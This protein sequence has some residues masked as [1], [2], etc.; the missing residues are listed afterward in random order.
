MKSLM[1]TCVYASLHVEELDIVGLVGKTKYDELKSST[2]KLSDDVSPDTAFDWLELAESVRL[3][4]VLA[5]HQKL[6]F[7][8][9]RELH[10]RWLVFDQ[11]FS[12]SLGKAEAK[13]ALPCL[14]QF[15]MSDDLE[16]S[17]I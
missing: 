3:S 2:C 4:E 5:C 16:T 8:K 17:T 14:R 10:Q 11:I 7:S 13:D 12:A 15:S 6:L 9:V 1:A